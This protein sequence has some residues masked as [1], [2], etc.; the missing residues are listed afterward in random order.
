[1]SGADDPTRLDRAVASFG[2]QGPTDTDI[3]ESS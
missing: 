2:G 1:M 3:V